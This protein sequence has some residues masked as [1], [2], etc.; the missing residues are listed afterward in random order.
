MSEINI[1]VTNGVQ[2]TVRGDS[3]DYIISSGKVTKIFYDD[4]VN[5]DFGYSA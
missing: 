2:I 3:P 1:D 4:K 5:K